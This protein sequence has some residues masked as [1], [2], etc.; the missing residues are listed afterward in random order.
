[1]PKKYIKLW[2]R[3]YTLHRM[4]Q[5]VRAINAPLARRLMGFTVPSVLA[6]GFPRSQAAFYANPLEWQ[7]FICFLEGVFNSPRK[8][9]WFLDHY[10]ETKHRY[11]QTS[12]KINPISWR[13]L[14][15]E[16][17]VNKLDNYFAA[18]DAFMLIGQMWPHHIAEISEK[19]IKQFV[20]KHTNSTKEQAYLLGVIFSPSKMSQIRLEQ[21]HM[22]EVALAPSKKRSAMLDNHVERFQWIPSI[23]IFDPPPWTKK[24]FEKE[25]KKLVSQ[26]TAAIEL[27]NMRRQISNARSRYRKARMIFHGRERQMVDQAHEMS[28]IKDDR[29]DTRRLG[30]FLV[31]PLYQE[32]K[33]RLDILI[34]DLMLYTCEEVKTALLNNSTLAT[35]ELRARSKLYTIQANH[36]QVTVNTG[37]RADRLKAQVSLE[38]QKNMNSFTG[39][40]ASSGRVIGTVKIVQKVED[41]SKVKTNDIIVSVTTHPDYLSVMRRA[42]AFVTD[43]GGLTSHAAI[44]ARELDK[45]CIVGTKIA[46]KTFKDG[47]QIE[48]NADK[49]IVR[50][51]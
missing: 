14:S 11:L 26:K 1:M 2:A 39:L 19:K 28:F 10:T 25:L 35:K 31:R 24:Y 37:T 12:K 22:L 41:L 36:G 3:E 7:R 42:S 50:K 40:I 32:I 23:N 4:E 44:V 49:G 48:V 27:R 34:E 51:I 47:D 29:D 6:V 30:Y 13:Q 21:K 16:Q 46:T 18:H 15:K 45:P 43:E 9:S 5:V 8:F 33:R 38:E 20:E 17:L